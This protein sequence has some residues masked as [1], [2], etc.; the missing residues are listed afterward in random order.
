MNDDQYI[1]MAARVLCGK[2]TATEKQ[3]FVADLLINDSH[4]MWFAAERKEFNR[5]I[6]AGHTAKEY[7]HWHCVGR[8]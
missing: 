6:K 8:G 4:L 2:A 7:W 3:Q 5:W 1:E